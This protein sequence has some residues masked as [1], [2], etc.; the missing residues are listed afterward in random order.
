MSEQASFFRLGLFTLGSLF[1]LLGGLVTIGARN[2][3][4]DTV[5]VE[6]VLAE[7][8]SGLD[9]GGPVKHLGVKIGTVSR[10]SFAGREYAIEAGPDRARL[11]GLVLVEMKL[12]ERALTTE[13]LGNALPALVDAGLRARM[14]TSGFVGPPFLD[15][16]IVDPSANP[17]LALPWTP[18]RP[19]VP[20]IPSLIGRV[21]SAVESLAVKLS[22]A[23]VDAL[24]QDSDALVK[25]AREALAGVQAHEISDDIRGV[26]ADLRG[27]VARLNGVLGDADKLRPVF[28]D[29]PEISRHVRSL[30]E[31]LDSE[32]T[33]RTLDNVASASDTMPAVARDLRRLVRRLDELVES[34]HADIE[35]ILTGVRQLTE[36][37]SRNPS[38]AFFGEPP[39]RKEPGAR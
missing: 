14:A 36:D 35:A 39:P 31:R 19:Y 38:R 33:T 30:A 22:Q 13:S 11:E 23:G 8:A 18:H 3:F 4:R 2:V 10:I 29:L 37:A 17:P 34:E 7:S 21:E 20:S 5:T 9:V 6:T 16:A 1:L 12:D 32:E 15:L 24:V 25:Q 28:A 26:L 27:T